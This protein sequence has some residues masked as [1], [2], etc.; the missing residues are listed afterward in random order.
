[1][2]VANLNLEE[3]KALIKE[4]VKE[5]IEV[6]LEDP[7]RGLELREEFIEELKAT[8]AAKERIPIEEIAKELG[9]YRGFKFVT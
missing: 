9:L 4:A 2:K 8:L 7:D 6:L 5:E 3:L 1:M